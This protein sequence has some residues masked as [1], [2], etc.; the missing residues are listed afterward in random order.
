MD[1][2]TETQR[3]HYSQRG[4]SGAVGHFNGSGFHFSVP[5]TEQ[6]NGNPDGSVDLALAHLTN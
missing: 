3:T 5:T 1:T 2:A 6:K 4:L